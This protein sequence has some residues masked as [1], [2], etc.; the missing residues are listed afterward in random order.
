MRLEGNKVILESTACTCTYSGKPGTVAKRISCPK[1]G[2][3]GNGLKGGRN[4]CKKCYGFG[5]T[6]SD[7]ETVTCTA[8]NGTALVPENNCNTMPD[9][10]YLSLPFKVYRHERSLTYGESLLGWGCVYSCTDYGDAFSA[11]D[12]SVIADV[13]THLYVQLCKVAN[14]ENQLCDHVGIFIA[15]N[16]YSVRGVFRSDGLDA[17][18]EIASQNSYAD[19]MQQG[20]AIARDGGNG[21]LG[22][23]YKV[24]R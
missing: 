5:T 14:K 20:T 12:E 11:S 21:T 7:T 15:R 6:Y 3:T 9:E 2:G 19:G 23:I 22:G 13:R 16:G 17:I 1:C 10:M 4:G 8:C 18:A 24:V